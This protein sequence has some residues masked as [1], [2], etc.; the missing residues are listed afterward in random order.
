VLDA[1]DA[2]QELAPSPVT[3]VHRAVAVGMLS[4]AA[5]A[6]Q[7]LD[8]ID[9]AAVPARYPWYHATR[10]HWLRE[11]GDATGAAAAYRR[12]LALTGAVPARAFL[13]DRLR[14]V[15]G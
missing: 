10:A 4:G 2:L 5:A 13:R 11:A 6:L 7:A 12:A 15:R 9:D 3:Q 8:A 14:E 1:Y